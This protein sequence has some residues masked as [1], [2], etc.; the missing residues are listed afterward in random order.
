MEVPKPPKIPIYQLMGEPGSL[1]AD[2]S[3]AF[4]RAAPAGHAPVYLATDFAF[5]DVYGVG[6]TLDTRA[7]LVGTASV[8]APGADAHSLRVYFRVTAWSIFET[9]EWAAEWAK[10]PYGDY[11]IC[12]KGDHGEF[13]LSASHPSYKSVNNVFL[14]R[15]SLALGT[16]RALTEGPQDASYDDIVPNLSLGSDSETKLLCNYKFVVDFI[17]KNYPAFS[18][19]KFIAGLTAKAAKSSEVYETP[20]EEKWRRASCHICRLVPKYPRGRKRTDEENR[21]AQGLII[22]CH[23]C[24][25]HW[26]RSCLCAVFGQTLQAFK[27]DRECP[28]CKGSCYCEGCRAKKKEEPLE[29]VVRL[30]DAV[31]EH[32]KTVFHVKK[33]R[34][35]QPL[36]ASKSD[37]EGGAEADEDEQPSRKKSKHAGSGDESE[38]EGKHHHR[39]HHHHKDRKDKDEGGSKRQVSI[40]QYAYPKS[41]ID[42]ARREL[43]L[44]SK[45]ERRKRVQREESS[46][47]RQL[48]RL[49]CDELD[50]APR[51]LQATAAATAASASTKVKY[52]VDDEERAAILAAKKKA[53]PV[54]PAPTLLTTTSAV[55]I[56]ELLCV[57]QFLSSFGSLLVRPE[58]AP[59]VP[60]LAR[61][62]SAAPTR[63][64]CAWVAALNSNLL[65]TL[66]RAEGSADADEDDVDETTCWELVRRR[67]EATLRANDAE[68][69][70]LIDALE[71]RDYF[72]L[73]PALRLKVTRALCDDVLD[74]DA[75][76]DRVDACVAELAEIKAQK[77]ELAREKKE[78][79]L[80]SEP[81][82]AGEAVAAATTRAQKT[83]EARER[84]AAQEREERERQL[85]AAEARALNVLRTPCLGCDRAMRRY[86]L[87][88]GRF[89][90]VEDPAG[91]CGGGAWHAVATRE[92]YEA[93]M[94]WLDI[95]GV[96][97]KALDRVL[98]NT[99]QR[100]VDGLRPLREMLGVPEGAADVLP[101]IDLQCPPPA[102]PKP[103]ASAAAEGQD[104][105]AKPA[106]G[107]GEQHEGGE[108]PAAAQEA[109]AAQGADETMPMD[110][111]LSA[112]V[113]ESVRPFS[114][115]A[116]AD[117][118]AIIEDK[119][120]DDFITPDFKEAREEW[121][122]GL[123]S[124][125]TLAEVVAKLLQ[126]HG[127]IRGSALDA[128]KD[129]E[130]AGREAW[131]ARVAGARTPSQVAVA[132]RQYHGI[133]PWIS[134]CK[135]CK[136]GDLK[137]R[138][139][140]CVHC[141]RAW[142]L[143]CAG[144][145]RTP[146][147]DWFCAGCK[148]AEQ[149]LAS[150][151]K[152]QCE[153]CNGT[154]KLL[155]CDRCP[156]VYHVHCVNL[157]RVPRGEWICPY[158]ESKADG[159][160][161]ASGDRGAKAAGRARVHAMAE[162]QRSSSD[163][164][165]EGERD[166]NSS[167]ED[168]DY[169][170]ASRASSS[171]G[172]TSASSG[173]SSSSSS[174]SSS[175]DEGEDDDE[176]DEDERPPRGARAMPRRAA[177]T[178]A[179]ARLQA[180]QGGASGKGARGDSDDDEE[181]ARMA[182]VEHR[183]RLGLRP[184]AKRHYQ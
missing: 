114:I 164:E 28:V 109:Q 166:K 176:D 1:D 10:F 76:R 30:A 152:E 120:E 130:P 107:Q 61:V 127:G 148:R 9:P 77:K 113:P 21:V 42:K 24:S 142:H 90:L 159:A 80:S 144:L 151:S 182:E 2:L 52:P 13:W 117:L 8:V 123:D 82:G 4:A 181:I 129:W 99:E 48:L 89:L 29:V 102:L 155:C 66:L 112:A 172:N 175:E 35:N 111:D 119:L 3:A 106:E 118:V 138:L 68:K 149:E 174:E 86:W 171:A 49:V 36:V 116:V 177:A 64:A 71:E 57:W 79:D 11:V 143:A 168:E 95:K 62:F 27:T 153:V 67:F 53:V 139:I 179:S 125:A 136:R 17:A 70:Q 162:E 74:T 135:Q 150:R 91:G 46:T 32:W 147:E 126:L 37:D 115:A 132:C 22:K 140:R 63:E 58:P 33:K 169:K 88:E 104:A 157:S 12:A 25:R 163:D 108:A 92:Q 31:G 54:W 161:A 105:A 26:C 97:E 14:W 131:E 122:K 146:E 110:V 167:D 134:V 137:S 141:K 7:P 156:R 184:L 75:A 98:T 5:T 50:N 158:C 84:K 93:I 19:S 94:R 165:S 100:V 59:A 85:D 180:K 44:L 40:V 41:A 83:K 6:C 128:P 101:Q 87:F 78:L 154:G 38:R 124:A 145:K 15:A 103:P 16:A 69:K 160:A 173:S 170:T 18:S 121:R 65:R 81:A 39:H 72:E 23:R 43:E 55:D 96:R 60:L 178:R 183:S 20:D 45:D 56:G 51:E 47:R 133:C 34:Q 73:T